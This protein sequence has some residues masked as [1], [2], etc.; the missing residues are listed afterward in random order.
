MGMIGEYARLTPDEVRRCV[1]DP[2][3]A[4]TLVRDELDARRRLDVDKAW[5]AMQHLMGRAGLAVDVVLGGE[6]LDEAG[7]WGYGPPRRLAAD[8]VAAAAQ[9]M[10]GLPWD[11]LVAGVTP[12]DLGE[13]DVYPHI[14]D[15]SDAFDYVRPYYEALSAF[16]GTAAREGDSVL[17]WIS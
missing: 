14:W 15:E 2:D 11:R 5:C 6:P 4:S 3:G 12:A 16:F 7:D 8:Q 1:H 9:E 10:G 17:L 13:A